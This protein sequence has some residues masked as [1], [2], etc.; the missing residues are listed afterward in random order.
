MEVSAPYV[1]SH[2]SV[3]HIRKCG[4]QLTIGCAGKP[5]LELCVHADLINTFIIYQY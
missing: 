4:R 5:I 1:S 2:P 3:E